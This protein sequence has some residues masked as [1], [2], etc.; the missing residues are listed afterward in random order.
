MLPMRCQHTA[1]PP[2]LAVSFCVMC[3]LQIFSMFVAF[4]LHTYI[5]LLCGVPFLTCGHGVLRTAS[6]GGQAGFCEFP[7]FLDRY[8][9]VGN[10]HQFAIVQ[11]YGIVNC[12]CL[13]RKRHSTHAC[14]ATKSR[15]PPTPQVPQR[16]SVQDFREN[17]IHKATSRPM[18]LEVRARWTSL[19]SRF[20]RA[21]LPSL[22]AA[23]KAHTP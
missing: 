7:C 1:C 16:F 13:R 20:L 10:L 17:A 6:G 3:L 19:R 22:E 9:K 23:C 14:I 8:R 12:R 21:H 18:I 5:F 11:N 15:R 2:Q 4:P